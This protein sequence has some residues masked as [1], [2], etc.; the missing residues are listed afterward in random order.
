MAN[1]KEATTKKASSAK[2]EITSKDFFE[3][4]DGLEAAT[5]I[6]K[7]QF[8]EY[9]A[10]GI[11]SAYKKE[12]GEARNILIQLNPEKCTIRVT[13]YKKIVEEVEDPEKEI[14][15]EDALEIN[16]KA[17]IGGVISEDLKPKE[18]SRIAAQTAKQVITQKLND[19]TKSIVLEEMSKKEGEIVSC[20]IRRIEGDNIYVDISGSTMEGLMLKGDQVPTEEYSV[21]QRLKVYVRK[22]STDT[23]GNSHVLVSRTNNGFIRR[24]FEMEIP[25]IKAGLVVI[26][27]IVREPGY[28]TK[29][30][31]A[32]TD[33]TI[34]AVGACIG[35]KGM[36]ITNIVDE[37]NGENIDIVPY[38]EDKREFI[39]R[40]LSP[41][42]VV[43]VAI[44]ETLN[45]AKA[46]VPDDMYLKAIGKK[47]YNA[48]LAVKLTDFKIDVKKMSEESEGT[49]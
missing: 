14:S 40:A 4:L 20:Q 17:Q 29:V 15:L 24:L 33:P 2:K 19:A 39:A 10:A 27:K 5:K 11:S 42:K 3:A 8:I 1:K 18:F 49:Y 48:K 36:R 25:E 47:G 45:T 32:A 44:N 46:L 35:Q 28:R 6:T 43:A 34:D 22:I 16:P 37:I 31:I 23:R 30:A 41:A 26:K 21:G 9:L 7:E 13:A 12:C 38:C